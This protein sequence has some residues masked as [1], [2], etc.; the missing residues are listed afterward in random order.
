MTDEPK[1]EPTQ[2]DR[3]AAAD[4]V[5]AYRELKNYN[6][7]QRIRQGDADDGEMVQAF[8]RHRLQAVAEER[9]RVV[10]FIRDNVQVLSSD[11]RHPTYWS[12]RRDGN[13]FAIE[14]ADAIARGQ[15]DEGEHHE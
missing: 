4:V 2:A 1:I 3:E 13:S 6:W 10:S 11:E 12:K 14:Y 7:Q 5:K 15:H 9:E 8:A